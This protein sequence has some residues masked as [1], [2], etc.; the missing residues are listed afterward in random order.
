MESE[1]CDLGVI[2]WPKPFKRPLEGQKAYEGLDASGKK[3]RTLSS[4]DDYLPPLDF[5]F[6]K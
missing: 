5:S 1:N 6:V 3:V 2:G 4:N